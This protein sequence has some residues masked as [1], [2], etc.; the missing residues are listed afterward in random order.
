MRKG[1]HVI[2]SITCFVTL[3][4]ISANHKSFKQSQMYNWYL[5]QSKVK[6]RSDTDKS[7][8]GQSQVSKPFTEFL[9][10]YQSL[11]EWKGKGRGGDWGGELTTTSYIGLFISSRVQYNVLELNQISLKK[12]LLTLDPIPYSPCIIYDYGSC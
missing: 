1:A 3:R 6:S 10:N 9:A 7:A 8:V 4:S 5:K 12:S 2:S 11:D